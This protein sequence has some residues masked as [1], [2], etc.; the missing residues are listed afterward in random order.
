M[1]ASGRWDL[2]RLLRGL[3]VKELPTWQAWVNQK[4]PPSMGGCTELNK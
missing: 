4:V 1:P 3:M 2:T